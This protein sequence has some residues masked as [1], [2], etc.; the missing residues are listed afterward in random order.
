[1][2]LEKMSDFFTVRA[3]G[4]DTHMLTNVEGCQKGYTRVAE[5]VGEHYAEIGQ[6]HPT[7]LDLGCGTGLELEEIFKCLPNLS[8][9]GI[10]LTEA[11]LDK[12]REKFPKKNLHLIC[13]SYFDVDFGIASYGCAVSFQTMHHFSHKKKSGLYSR[14]FEALKPGGIYVECDYMVE[15][16]EEENFYFAE[17]ARLRN[18][19]RIPQE[20]FFHYDTPCTI[21]NQ[22][23]MLE[24]VGFHSVKKVFR[25]E[26]TT[27]LVAKKE[28]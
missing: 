13:G 15:K 11:M 20:A 16:Q 4:Y 18:E 14:V 6:Q 10:D 27:I 22:I 12:L 5:I 9:T 28:K 8:V 21:A 26:N 1:M 23:A 7:L 2:E 17:N 19:Q 3:D 24:T 25:I